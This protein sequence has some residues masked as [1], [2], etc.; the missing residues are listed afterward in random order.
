MRMQV[1]AF[2]KIE[3]AQGVSVGEVLL[4]KDF[5]AVVYDNFANNR[6]RF[7]GRD[8]DQ[9]DHREH[10]EHRDHRE[11]RD[12]RGGDRRQ[13]QYQNYNNNQNYNNFQD[14]KSY[15]TFS[16]NDT[17]SEATFLSSQVGK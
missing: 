16:V 5:S 13:H 12:Y 6:K 9:R 7:N 4:E 8:R 1:D 14:N 15:Q 17:V 3:E 10:R 2:G 11:Y